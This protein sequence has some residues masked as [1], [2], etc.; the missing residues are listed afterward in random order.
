MPSEI[1]NATVCRAEPTRTDKP[2]PAGR[3]DITGELPDLTS[4]DWETVYR[5]FYTDEAARILGVLTATLPGGTL[6][7]LFA[8]M[9]ADR[10]SLFRVPGGPS[11][12]RHPAPGV[13]QWCVFVG[14][15]DPDNAALT[16]VYDD[17][18]DAREQ[19]QWFTSEHG[20]GLARRDVVASDWIVLATDGPIAD[21]GTEGG[22]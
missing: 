19:L 11:K 9:A 14:G 1:L 20:R 21:D 15:P 22:E 7:A 5:G 12:P 4:A 13:A 18:A 10:A 3:I 16:R 6:D 8:A 2:A 17:E